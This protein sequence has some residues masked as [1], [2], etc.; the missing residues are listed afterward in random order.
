MRSNNRHKPTNGREVSA[1]ILVM[2]GEGWVVG[3][4]R[5]VEERTLNGRGNSTSTSANSEKIVLV[6][7]GAEEC[8][9]VGF[10][11]GGGSL[12]PSGK[13]RGKKSHSL[14]PEVCCRPTNIFR[15]AFRKTE[16]TQLSL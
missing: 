11:V 10:T 2:F 13:S 15:L 6:T 14:M 8:G 1:T 3:C 9:G 4:S 7:H 16:R 5:V 12:G